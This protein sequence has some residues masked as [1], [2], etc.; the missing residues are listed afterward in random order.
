MLPLYIIFRLVLSAM[1]CGLMAL[2]VIVLKMGSNL[3]NREGAPT[4]TEGT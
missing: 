1:W 3:N 4:H 2:V